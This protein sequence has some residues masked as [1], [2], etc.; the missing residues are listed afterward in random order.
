MTIK[1]KY[2][3]FLANIKLKSMPGRTHKSVQLIKYNKHI[4]AQKNT[5]KIH[6]ITKGHNSKRHYSQ[7]EI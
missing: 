5:N 4:L 3:E 1:H 6:L 7:S 2:K